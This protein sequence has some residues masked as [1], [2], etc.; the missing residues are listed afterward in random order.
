MNSKKSINKLA[1]LASLLM[2]S[3][4]AFAVV[5]EEVNQKADNN[6][7]ALQTTQAG[8]KATADGLNAEIAAR[9]AADTVLQNNINTIS[10]TP[11]PQGEQGIQGLTGDAGSNG[12]NGTNGNDGIAGADGTSC[13]VAQGSG[14]A[15]ITCGDASNVT[16]ASVYD[17]ADGSSV[18][19]N[20]QGDMQYW[21]GTNWV[22]IAAP[23]GV[24]NGSTGLY[25][26]KG[27]PTWGLCTYAIGETGPAG[28]IVFYVTDGGFHGLEAAP[29]DQVSAAWGCYGTALSDAT[30][31]TM[32]GTGA[33]NTAAIV[34]ECAEAGTAAKV[35]DAYTLNGYGDWFLPSKGELNLL[36]WQKQLGVVGGFTSGFYWSSSQSSSLSNSSLAWLQ[37]FGNGSQ[38]RLN[39][40]ATAGVRAVRAF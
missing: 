11:G 20:T 39:K 7:A 27:V 15:T 38:L 6:S 24:I 19:G 8:A 10:L 12:T 22:L 37:D 2:C 13:A 36:Y 4:V 9:I 1:I 35:A 21:N 23:A 31:G 17:G 28:G 26:C 29:V 5:V 18:S 3:N 40:G 30:E 33:A 14:S 32:V 16:M 25:F 34:A